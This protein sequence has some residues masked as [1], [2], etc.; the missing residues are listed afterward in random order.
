MPA[1]LFPCGTGA[2]LTITGIM[3][4]RDTWDSATATVAEE[5]SRLPAGRRAAV[6]AAVAAIKACKSA[7]HNVVDAVDA[8]VVCASCGGACCMSGKYH[9]TV[10]DLLAY[11]VDE[12]ELFAPHF[13]RGVCPY[14]DSRGC[15]MAPPYRPFTCVIFNC[16]LVEGLLDLLQKKLLRDLESEL[17]GHYAGL[18]DLFGSR[19]MGGVL[20]NGE[21]AGLSGRRA[22]L[23][24]NGCLRGERASTAGRI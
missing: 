24:G 18:E 15:R 8:G 11:L 10:V 2:A 21:R 6:E 12:K 20:M 1:I 7:L 4:D 19:F 9:F 13:G 23:D 14:L 17:R 5:F 22:I 16:E 3:T